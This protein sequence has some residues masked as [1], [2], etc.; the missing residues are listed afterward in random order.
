MVASTE[1]IIV[2]LTDEQ[3]ESATAEGVGVLVSAD[4]DGFVPCE[5]V[6]STIG[7]AV[8]GPNVDGGV[9][10]RSGDGAREVGSVE[11]DFGSVVRGDGGSRGYLDLGL[12]CSG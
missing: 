11:T 1:T 12:P 7:E 4:L 5:W 3:T 2:L 6:V 10:A 8:V 9:P